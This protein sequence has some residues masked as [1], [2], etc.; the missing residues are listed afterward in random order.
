MN[1]THVLFVL[2]SI[3]LGILGSRFIYKR[4]VMFVVV[5]ILIVLI[6]MGALMGY[7]M[8]SLSIYHWLWIVPLFGTA[9]TLG[10]LY[11]K[12]HIGSALDQIVKLMAN[13][14]NGNLQIDISSK[15]L[16]RN[17]ELGDIAK[18]FVDMTASI[19]QVVD[20]VREGADS[21]AT[22]S[23]HF[24]HN[25][26]LLSKGASEQASSTEEVS[27]SMEQM[28]ANIQQNMESAQTADR[29]SQRVQDGMKLVESSSRES[30]T[31]IQ[32]I[33][34]KIGVINDIAFQTNILALNAAVEAARA[35][36]HGR[37]FAV[38]AAEVRRLAE[39]SKQAAGDIVALSDRSVQITEEAAQNLSNFIPEI[40]RVVRL[41]QEIAAASA[42]QASGADQ[43]NSA[44]QQLNNVTQH[45]AVSSEEI[46]NSA[47]DVSKQAELLRGVIA[48][49][50]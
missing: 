43:V 13:I 29:L 37:G 2:I 50:S 27:S 26:E 31:S 45:N 7:A 35:G 32:E 18:A 9:M 6:S 25:A 46:S 12:K 4:S 17:D 11:I 40:V 23:H 39:Q 48:F 1:F 42:E 8:N 38:V 21:I 15:L 3:P 30:L 28:T 24:T 34:T 41:V 36:E 49:Y 20:G 14:S 5:S 33:S 19:K 10:M 22:S 47:Q 44:I 16:S